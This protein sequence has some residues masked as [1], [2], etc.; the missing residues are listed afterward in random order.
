MSG[1]VVFCLVLA[2]ISLCMSV[3]A[4]RRDRALDWR[5][6]VPQTVEPQGDPTF[7]TVLDYTPA[8]GQA[9]SPGIMVDKGAFRILWFED[10][11]PKDPHM[12]L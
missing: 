8:T 12:I 6:M 1:G 10:F 9:H 7:E 11:A 2:G 3:W 4:M 5:F